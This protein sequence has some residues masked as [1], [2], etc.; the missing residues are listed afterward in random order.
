MDCRLHPCRLTEAVWLPLI[1]FA[2]SPDPTRHK[3][4]AEEVED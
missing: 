2:R 4:L 1:Y 3:D